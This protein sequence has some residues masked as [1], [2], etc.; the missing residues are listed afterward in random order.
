M[1]RNPGPQAFIERF[2]NDDIIP[3]VLLHAAPGLAIPIHAPYPELEAF[4]LRFAGKP[5]SFR[6]VGE[7]IAFKSE[8]STYHSQEV[9]L[10]IRCRRGEAVL[11]K[12][13]VED[14]DIELGS[15]EV[16]NDIRLVE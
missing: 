14:G 2:H 6:D 10:S 11:N 15:V 12:L 1:L 7:F 9:N 8:R 16:D 4:V 3:V 13:T 5:K